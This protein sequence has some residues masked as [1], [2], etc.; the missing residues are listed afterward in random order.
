M[1][2]AIAPFPGLRTMFAYNPGPFNKNWGCNIG[3]RQSQGSLLAFGNADIV[4]RSF[5][6]AVAIGRSGV[7]VVR[8]FRGV[9]DLDEAKSA[10]LHRDLSVL[11]EPAFGQGPTDRTGLGENVPLCGGLVIFDWRYLVLLGGWNER[12]LGWGGEVDAMDIKVQRAGLPNVVKD[13]A[14]GFSVPPAGH[15]RTQGYAGLQ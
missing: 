1:L 2:G 13:T 7:P 11:S 3:V 15:R 14:D 5:P 9:I 4:C 12:F 10:L 6:D 8:S